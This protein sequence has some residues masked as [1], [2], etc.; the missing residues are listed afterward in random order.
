MV[1]RESAPVV[2]AVAAVAAP[3]ASAPLMGFVR[4]PISAVAALP[5]FTLFGSPRPCL[6]PVL[7]SVMSHHH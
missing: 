2:A 3:T 5:P 7:A 4:L 6:P 1:L